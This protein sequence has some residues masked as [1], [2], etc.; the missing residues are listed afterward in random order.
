MKMK[1]ISAVLALCSLTSEAYAARSSVK[2][3]CT[4]LTD[5]T[6]TI[7]VKSHCLRSGKRTDQNSLAVDVDQST[8]AIRIKGDFTVE[9]GYHIGP[10]DC[11][12]STQF[13][14]QAKDIEPRR[15]K[16]LFGSQ[17]LG[18]VD[19]TETLNQKPCFKVFAGAG[20]HPLIRERDLENWS[21][22]MVTGWSDWTEDNLPALVRPLVGSFP[23]NIV[24]NP[25]FTLSVERSRWVPSV[26]K[27]P[28]PPHRQYQQVMTV[29][30]TQNGL[31][32]DSVTA[33]RFVG[34]AKQGPKGWYFHRLYSQHMCGRGPN[35]GQWTTS[36]CP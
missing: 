3:I 19:F 34:I 9:Y 23:D 18:R 20:E 22:D 15:Y 28:F 10:T 29:R 6:L 12:G 30:L 17:Y 7:T 1:W 25:Q 8:A 11:M 31:G 13:D 14:L 35:A 26:V 36:S 2:S 5:K 21:Q 24:G 4:S 16:L 27:K 33:N 32:D